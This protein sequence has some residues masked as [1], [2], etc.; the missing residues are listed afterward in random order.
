MTPRPAKIALIGFLAGH[1]VIPNHWLHLGWLLAFGGYALR[2]V[3]IGGLGAAWRRDFALLTC[4]AYLAWMTLRSACSASLLTSAAIPDVI[5]GLVGAALLVVL[6]AM[7]WLASADRSV[8]QRAAYTIGF[9]SAAAAAVSIPVGY[10]VLHQNWIHWRLE[11]LL[12]HGGLNP[13]CTGLVFGFAGLGLAAADGC[14][15][16]PLPRRFLWPAIVLLHWA[17]Y[18][19]AS[20]G[21]LLA[22]ACGH[23]TLIVVSVG[24]RGK[25]AFLS[26]LVGGLAYFFIGPICRLLQQPTPRAA[27]EQIE[28]P[29]GFL[30]RGSAGRDEIYRAGFRAVDNIW[31]GT[32][33]WGT[34]GQWRGNLS[35]SLSQDDLVSHLHSA[36]LATYVQGGIVGVI[37]LLGIIASAL[38]RSW[39]LARDGQ[40]IWMSLLVYGLVGLLF[41]GESLT[42]LATTPRLEG[43]LFWWPVMASLTLAGRSLPE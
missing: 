32:G 13:V 25:V 3:E 7:I 28:P 34:R 19:T 16:A 42:S 24:K 38:I 23:A 5:F 39:R 37:L 4:G 41:D 27:S 36:L 14:D 31:I 35:P 43:L 9:A 29:K 17:V 21:A 33:Q 40:V 11:N 6:W 22:L 12:V 20:R 15:T 1:S 30:E 10:L 8:M 26:L 18:L 2:S